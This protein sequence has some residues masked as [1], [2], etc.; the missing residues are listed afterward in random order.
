MLLWPSLH[1]PFER[2]L[3]DLTLWHN[4]GL[5]IWP[6]DLA[7]SLGLDAGSRVLRHVKTV[8]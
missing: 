3:H 5:G 4:Q 6:L 7:G 2:W 8:L 1:A